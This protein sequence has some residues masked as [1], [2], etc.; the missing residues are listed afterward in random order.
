MVKKKRTAT[1]GLIISNEEIIAEMPVVLTIIGY[2]NHELNFVSTFGIHGRGR[3]N[4][5]S[6]FGIH[7]RGRV[8]F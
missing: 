7:G 3:V 1:I 6:T 5:V 8:N 4:F 2:R